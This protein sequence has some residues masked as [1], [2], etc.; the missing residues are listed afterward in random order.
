MT[1]LAVGDV[2]TSPVLTLSAGTP[3][4]EAAA[5]ML[6]AG[7]KS[8]AVIDDDCRPVGILTSTDLVRLAADGVAPGDATVADYMTRDVVT[9]R[10]GVPLSRVAA[11]MIDADISHVPVVGDD[12]A[13]VGILTTTDLTRHLAGDALDVDGSDP[14]EGDDVDRGDPGEGDDV[15]GGDP[16]EA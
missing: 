12:G 2:M 15:D 5:G 6:E 1:D 14:G 16:D 4:D 10:A 3:V 7:I 9:T 11:R 8:L 13:V